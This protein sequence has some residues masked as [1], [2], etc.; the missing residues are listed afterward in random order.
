MPQGMQ[1]FMIFLAG[2]GFPE[3]ARTMDKMRNPHP[4]GQKG[5]M[6]KEAAGNPAMTNPGQAQ[7]I[8]RLAQMRQQ[9]GAQP[10]GAPP[11]PTQNPLA[12]AR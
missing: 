8:A 3:F 2:L 12:F 6:G 10:G 1:E 9:A 4:K 11:A 5:A 7:M